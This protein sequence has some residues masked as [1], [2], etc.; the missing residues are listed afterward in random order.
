MSNDA[1]F[2]K[3]WEGFLPPNAIVMGKRVPGETVPPQTDS[4]ANS[5]VAKIKIVLSQPLRGETNDL[6]LK[7]FQ[8]MN[9][10]ASDVEVMTE[11]EA[12]G[13]G[14]YVIRLTGGTQTG[15]VTDQ[16]LTTYSLEEMLADGKLKREVWSH[17]K[18]AQALIPK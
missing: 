7:I 13:A 16:G 3:T 6:L 4:L 17:L 10:Q 14:A 1:K 18:S 11:E 9:W 8:A 2:F 5:T 12:F 15:E